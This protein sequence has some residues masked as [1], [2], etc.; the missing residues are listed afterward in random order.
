[1]AVK[2]K[3]ERRGVILVADAG[4]DSLGVVSLAVEI[5]ASD[6]THLRGLFIEDEDLL[7][8]TGLPCSRVISSTTAR[9]SPIDIERMQRA[10]R[11]MGEQFRRALEREAHSLRAGWSFDYVRGR[12]REID[13]LSDG[14]VDFTI[15]GQP[16]GSDAAAARR[17][18]PRRI[19]LVGQHSERAQHV[20]RVL[21]R[22]FADRRIEVTLV[23]DN[24]GDDRALIEELAA[25]PG[26]RVSVVELA[27]SRLEQRLQADGRLFE[28]A[29]LS[30]SGAAADLNRIL[31]SLRCPV[32]LVA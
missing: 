16:L 26:N 19:L 4:C 23:V 14:D 31:A 10:L 28:F 11:S 30:R 32:V 5:A 15:I 9:E 13:L 24:G 17:R 21:L 27:R 12:M 22:H 25:L 20:L 3:S 8:L 18:E 2:V 6:D 7:Q 1:M 29:I